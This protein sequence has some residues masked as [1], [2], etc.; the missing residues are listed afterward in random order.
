MPS[1]TFT[2]TPTPS[3]SASPGVG[4]T[5]TPGAPDAFNRILEVQAW[6]NPNP[7][8]IRVKMDGSC[9]RLRVRIYS[10]AWVLLGESEGAGPD[11]AGWSSVDLPN[12][13]EVAAGTYF[14]RVHS[15]RAG[16][17]DLGGVTGKLVLL[18]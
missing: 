4:G 11:R 6:P 18:R 8:K 1:A 2:A 12:L 15:E 7:R 13:S 9:E 17:V 10:R 3:P 16:N 14:Y 5:T